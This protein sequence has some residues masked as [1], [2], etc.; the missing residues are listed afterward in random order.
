MTHFAVAIIGGGPGGYVSAIRLNQYGIDVAV[1]EKERLGGV[2][3]NHGCIPTKSL[4]KVADLFAEI[5]ESENFGIEVN[6]SQ[7]DYSKVWERKNSIVE[8]LVSGVEY[9]FQRRN[10]PNINELVIQIEKCEDHYKIISRNR[11]GEES[12][13]SADY[14]ILATG[15]IPQQL[16]FMRFDEKQILSSR[17]LL[18]M[19]ELPEHLVVVGG[20]VIGCEFASIY[21][22]MGVK[23]EIVELLPKLVFNE[24]EEISRRLAMAMK[25][26]GIKLHLNTAVESMMKDENQ[27]NLKLSNGKEI[28]TEKVLVSVGRVPHLDINI[29]NCELEL[30]SGFIQISD[31][32]E[33]NLSNVF[34]IGDITGK[35]MLAHSA[36]KQGLIV[37]DIINNEINADKKEIINLNYENIPR[38]TFT[39]PEIGSVGLTEK[40]AQERFGDILVGK[41]PFSANGKSLGIGNNFGFAKVIAETKDHKIV[42]MHIIGP[43]AT[44]L[45]AQGGILLGTDAK[46]ED[47][48]KIVFAHP[49]LSEV[50]MEAIEDLEKLSIHK[51]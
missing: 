31:K 9:L 35:L 11:E 39:N 47:I 17:D 25:K 19:Q 45:I 51:M 3:L 48:K 12:S 40:Q 38:C 44:E 1:F 28:S 16:P 26:S 43:Q 14:L 36:S 13:Y 8:R 20:G 18:K 6:S 41:F 34:A 24:D 37:A 5:K 15:S 32:M 10:I 50:V 33:T 4:V 2:C 21:Q 49:T 30:D 23:V 22:Q 7:I 42:G 27:M 29:K 46:I